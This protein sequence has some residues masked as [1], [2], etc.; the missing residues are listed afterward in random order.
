CG[1]RGQRRYGPSRT[2]RM[3]P[4][5]SSAPPST[6]SSRCLAPNVVPAG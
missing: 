1:R 6:T 5:R 2:A 3:V 4:H